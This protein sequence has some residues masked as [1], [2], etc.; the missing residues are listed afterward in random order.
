M[1]VQGH[2]EVPP[3][4]LDIIARHKMDLL[5]MRDTP[6]LDAGKF[7]DAT[8][9]NPAGAKVFSAIFVDRFARYLEAR[10]LGDKRNLANAQ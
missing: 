4:V 1:P 8:H 2:Y 10:K 6:G 3:Q 5:D 7:I 9:I